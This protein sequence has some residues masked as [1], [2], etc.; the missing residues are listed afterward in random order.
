VSSTCHIKLPFTKP[1]P[2]NFLEKRLKRKLFSA[3]LLDSW[4]ITSCRSDQANLLL[5]PPPQLPPT[6]PL[7]TA[8]TYQTRSKAQVIYQ[9]VLIFQFLIEIDRSCLLSN[10]C[11]CTLIAPGL[12]PAFIGRQN[13]QEAAFS[14]PDDGP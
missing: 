8:M 2:R 3:L 4:T 6:T 14:C 11:L 12:F 9:P 1:R 7:D 10:V 13:Y 5:P